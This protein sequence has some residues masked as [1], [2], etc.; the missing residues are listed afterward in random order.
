M[1][2]RIS[3]MWDGTSLPAETE[4]LV[5]EVKGGGGTIAGRDHLGWDAITARGFPVWESIYGLVKLFNV[6]L[7]VKL[8]HDWERSDIVENS[9]GDN[10]LMKIEFIIAIT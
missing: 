10:C 2:S 4:N 9:I 6:R 7:S 3:C 1:A 5:E 8:V